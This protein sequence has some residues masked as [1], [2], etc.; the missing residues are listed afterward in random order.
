M[1]QDVKQFLLDNGY[2]NSIEGIEIK[3]K[4]NIDSNITLKD[5]K[6]TKD[7]NLYIPKSHLK[8][9]LDDKPLS[10]FND[11]EFWKFTTIMK[12]LDAYDLW[13]EFNKKRDIYD[14]N[15]NIEIWNSV[16]P[17]RCNINLL[18]DL[19][20]NKDI[21]GYYN[22]KH[23]PKFSLESEKI[24]KNK[25]GYDFIQENINYIIKSDTGTGKT[26]SV[27]HF[28]NKTNDNFI[29]I[30]SRKSLGQEQYNNFNE[31]N[32]LKC[33]YYE[34]VDFIK[35]KDNIII[36][37]D[38]ILRIHRNIDLSQYILVLDEFESIIH[39]LFTSSTLKTKRVLI[40]MKFIEILKECYNFI[41][42]DEDITN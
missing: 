13:D 7:K 3:E 34:Y 29:S 32:F 26:T 18:I 41:C 8:Q 30:V 22:L 33:G 4:K 5:M 14:L 11:V 1:P 15:K 40:F 42:I 31:D 16:N 23:L 12:Y 10:F 39:Y 28:L 24:N 19:F 35:D 25:L 6:I 36:Q 38:S 37:L 20:H 17:N 21:S 9:I 27:K 2:D